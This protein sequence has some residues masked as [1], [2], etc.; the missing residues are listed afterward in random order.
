MTV[1]SKRAGHAV[2][3][4]GI[5]TNSQL[6]EEHIMLRDMVRS[7]ADTE[8]APNAGEWDKKFTPTHTP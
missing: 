4:R 7:F 1:A 6:S 8:L 2:Y 5:A 3:A